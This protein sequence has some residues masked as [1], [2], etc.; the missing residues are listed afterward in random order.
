MDDTAEKVKALLADLGIGDTGPGFAMGLL[1]ALYGK[2][3]ALRAERD[4]LLASLREAEQHCKGDGANDGLWLCCPG[5]AH[6]S[7]AHASGCTIGDALAR[8][9]NRPH[10]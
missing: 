2:M 10:L 6:S 5:V 1:A 8:A 9:A 3:D 7:G 4:A